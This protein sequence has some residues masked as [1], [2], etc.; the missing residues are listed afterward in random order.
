MHIV[1]NIA[2]FY[3]PAGM[4][5][6]LADKA[7]WLAAHGHRVTI[8]TT[9][10]KGRP[11]VFPLPEGVRMID[12]AIGYE[13]NNGKGLLDKLM[14]YPAKQRKHMRAL[15]RVLRELRPDVT[16]SMFCNEVNLIPRIKDGSVKV[17]EV[18]FSRF[19]RL[20]YA[21]KGLWAIVDRWRSGQESRIVR[22]YARFVVL[23]Q[24]DRLNWGQM[25]GIRVIPNPVSFRPAHPAPLDTK[26]VIAVGR[27]THQKGLE[28]LLDAWNL[29][30]EKTGWKLRLVGDG[31]DRP[32][33]EK[34][35]EKLGIGGSVILGRSESDMASVYREASILALSSRYEGLPMALIESQA[36]GVPAVSF[37]CQCGPSEIIK[38]GKTG[39]LVPEG[40]IP[41]LA[42]G[43][44]RL[45]TDDVLRREMGRAAFADAGRWNMEQ[46]M[47]QWIRLFEEIL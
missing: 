16:V 7:G 3:R 18:H 15:D 12:L 35:I 19:K 44:E 34:Y 6:V 22:K 39:I 40:D 21:R 13:D 17:L 11:A 8:L 5:R 38:D 32:F 1:Y 42:R 45:M 29:I 23:T 33:L 4:E 43:L 26:T 24:A 31:E 10:Q 2:G 20:Q 37:D 14:H 30:P 25:D 47:P 41:A 28:R 27:Y 46:I 9:E 36:F